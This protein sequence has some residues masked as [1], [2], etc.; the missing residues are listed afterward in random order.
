MFTDVN[1][2][3]CGGTYWSEEQHFTL[4]VSKISLGFEEAFP[5][6]EFFEF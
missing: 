2:E 5:V 1:T 3:G 6:S 4:Y